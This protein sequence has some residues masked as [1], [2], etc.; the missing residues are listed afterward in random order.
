MSGKGDPSAL[1]AV[2]KSMVYPPVAELTTAS[3]DA[4]AV[5]PFDR[6]ADARTPEAPSTQVGW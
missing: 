4:A 6:F 2:P 1:R 5:P 3:G